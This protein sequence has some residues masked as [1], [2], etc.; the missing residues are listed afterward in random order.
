[1]L[2]IKYCNKQFIEN[3]L[4]IMHHNFANLRRKILTIEE[5]PWKQLLHSPIQGARARENL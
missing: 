3:K 2:S 5:K 4:K 1:M